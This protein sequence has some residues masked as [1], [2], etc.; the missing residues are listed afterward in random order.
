[1]K[2]VLLKSA[3]DGSCARE[4]DPYVNFLSARGYHTDLIETMSFTIC[5]CLFE[6]LYKWR[7]SHSCIVFCS[8]RAVAS[9]ASTNLIGLPEDLCFAVGPATSAAA[10]KLGFTTKGSHTGNAASLANYMLDNYSSEVSKKPVLLLTGAKHSP[11]L[12]NQLRQAGITVEEVV[13]YSHIPNPHFVAQLSAT[14]K[15]SE[16]DS[17]CLV[18]FSPSAVEASQAIFSPGCP[19]LDPNVHILAI[20]PTTA[21]KIKALSLPCSAICRSPTPEGV[22]ECLEQ[23]ANLD[24]NALA[25]DR[26]V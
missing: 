20:G 26:L 5:G 1:M 4:S 17:L 13:V 23:V 11:V 2:V 18:F 22:V 15:E 16:K 7:S 14:L 8:Q 6:R 21:E 12:S 3:I 19:E 25:G 10:S 24:G 9:F